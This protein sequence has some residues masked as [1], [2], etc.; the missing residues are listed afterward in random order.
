[1]ENNSHK[2]T[3]VSANK[4]YNFEILTYYFTKVIKYVFFICVYGTVKVINR[5]TMN[6][7]I[8]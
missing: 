2:V 5:V 3:E 8:E 7:I 6:N 1:M 4:K